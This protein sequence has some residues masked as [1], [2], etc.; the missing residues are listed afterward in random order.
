[1]TPSDPL[2]YFDAPG[3]FDEADEVHVSVTFTWDIARA[4]WLA[5]QWRHVAPVKI[6]GPAFNQP[7]AAFVPGMYVGAGSVI[8]SR[9]C[10]NK[11]WF[12]S[13]WR[14]EPALKELSITQG[15]N[16]LDDNILACSEQHIRSV[17]AMLKEQR[18]PVEFTGGLEAKRLLPWHAELLAWLKPKQ[19]FF[20]YD[21]PDDYEPLL[22]AAE[23]M[24][25]AGFTPQSHKVRAYVL[26]GYPRDTQEAALSR[27]RQ[28]A[29]LGIMPFPMLW[30]DE[31]GATTREWRKL[32]RENARAKIF[33]G[34]SAAEKL[35]SLQTSIQHSKAGSQSLDPKAEADTSGV[36]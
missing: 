16:V 6:G 5:G 2:A 23:L 29:G 8:T 19:L 36:A 28:V 26:M 24:W 30:R 10:P 17:F 3:F 18:H 14:R 20:A 15:W 11:C 31:S 27:L 32:Q 9:G 21:T 34:K 1:M 13:V 25:K 12:C 22:H 35:G 7:G 33:Y 4:E